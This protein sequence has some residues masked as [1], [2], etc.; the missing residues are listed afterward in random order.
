MRPGRCVTGAPRH[1]L[2]S[3]WAIACEVGL[4]RGRVGLAVWVPSGWANL[5]VRLHHSDK[6][7][8]E[9]ARQLHGRAYAPQCRRGS[10]ERPC[11]SWSGRGGC[12]GRLGG[13]RPGQRGRRRT[14]ASRGRRPWPG[15]NRG[16]GAQL[17][18][19][20][21]CRIPQRER[22]V[23]QAAWQS[24]GE[25]RAAVRRN[26]RARR[27]N[28]ARASS[29]QPRSGAPWPVPHVSGSFAS[30]LGAA[31]SHERGWP[32]ILDAARFE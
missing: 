19:A 20:P 27:A 21:I 4:G 7:P 18:P 22:G 11:R 23:T 15:P 10:C 8:T 12:H 9:S 13:C 2:C 24:R 30:R 32:R 14:A 6:M 25:A 28:T 31:G 29:R 16:A 1:S 17:L 3:S 26:V 5:R